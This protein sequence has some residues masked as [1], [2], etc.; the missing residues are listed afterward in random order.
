[1]DPT[2]ASRAMTE[3]EGRGLPAALLRHVGGQAPDHY[4]LLLAA[5]EPTDGDDRA[6]LAW[7]LPSDPGT[8]APGDA[9]AAERLEPH[10]AL[11]LRLREPRHL[12]GGRGRADPVRHGTW[13][14]TVGG[15]RCRVTLAWS[16]GAAVTLESDADGRWR[17]TCP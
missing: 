13:T 7:R 4:D 17:R 16:D 2:V 10:R 11:Y 8:L 5:R 1:M 14:G 9:L 6:C 3:I 15:G 12:G